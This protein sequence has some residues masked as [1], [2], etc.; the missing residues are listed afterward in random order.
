MKPPKKATHNANGDRINDDNVIMWSV[1]EVYDFLTIIRIIQTKGFFKP[2]GPSDQK[3]CRKLFR[4]KIIKR[5]RKQVGEDYVYIP[6]IISHNLW[7][8]FATEKTGYPEPK[9]QASG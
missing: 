5:R 6:G 9:D 2:R 1:D 8:E 4:G 3:I 7:N